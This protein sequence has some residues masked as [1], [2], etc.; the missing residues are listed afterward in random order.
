[1]LKIVANPDKASL[2]GC[3]TLPSIQKLLGGLGRRSVEGCGRL[4]Q[5]DR[6]RVEL[7]ASDQGDDL[8]LTAG[9]VAARFFEKCFVPLEGIKDANDPCPV[10]SLPSMGF[11]GEGMFEVVLDGAL[12]ECWTLV[13]IDDLLPI[14]RDG[15]PAE[16]P[17][18]PLD[19]PFVVRVKERKC[20]KQHR[21]PRTGRAG[22][23]KPVSGANRD[24]HAA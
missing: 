15:F 12:E 21:L 13:Q 17:T 23:S 11:Q 16:R 6:R 3:L 14:G 5:E 18:V 2:A 24:T 4:V 7:K 22:Q 10:E 19:G 1:L 8:G 20:S 9:E